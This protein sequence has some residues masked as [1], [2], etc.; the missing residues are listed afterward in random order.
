MD[1]ASRLAAC[2]VVSKNHLAYAR[3]FS[4]SFL[5]HH[6]GARLFVLLADRIDGEFTPAREPFELIELE[7]L[8]I[9][10]LPRFCFQ[11]NILELNCA[12]KPYLLRH[13]L[14]QPGITRVLYLDSDT[15]VYREL[16]EVLD[17]LERRSIVLTPHLT[18][19]AE[20]DGLKPAE[21]HIME[22]GV[23]N[24][25]FLGVRNDA[26]AA[27]FLEWWS[28]RVYDKCIADPRQGLFVDQRWLDLVPG[29]FDGVEILRHPGYNLGHWG[30]PHRR[31]ESIGG[32][33]QV[34]GAALAFFHFSGLDVDK[35][36]LISKHQDRFSLHDVPAL[37]PLFDDYVARVKAAGFAQCQTWPY[38]HARFDNGVFIPPDARRLYWSLGDGARRF[39]D[40]FQTGRGSFW[41][42]LQEEAQEGSGLSRYW[43]HVY[44]TRPDVQR[45]F[46]DVFGRD[47]LA[48]R[49]WVLN[50]GRWEHQSPEA[51]VPVGPA[52]RRAAALRPP[53]KGRARRSAGRQR[54]RQHAV[55]EGHG[56]GSE[57]H[58]AQ[59]GRRPGA[60]R[61]RGRAR[62]G[63]GQPRPVGGRRDAREPVPDQPD[64]R[65]RPRPTQVRAQPRPALLPRQVQHRLLAVGAARAAR[66]VSRQ[67]L[68]PRRG[69]GGQHLRPGSRVPRLAHPRGEGAALDSG[70]GPAHRKRRPRLL[71]AGGGSARLPLHVRRAQRRGTEEP[72]RGH[73][74]LQACVPGRA[75]RAAGAEDRPRGA[76]ACARNSKASMRASSSWTGCS[77]AKHVNALIAACDCYVSLHRSEGFGL[78]LAEA[79]ALGKPVI[80]TGYS[81]NLDFMNVSNSL[82]VRYELV[83]AGGGPS[84][85][86]ARQR[87]GRAR[88]G[89]RRGADACGLRAIRRGP[90]SWATA[91]ARSVMA[92]L[93][94][95][96]VGARIRQRLS[97]IGRDL[98]APGSIFRE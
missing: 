15:F 54:R 12:G 21:R 82:L 19:D 50:A 47:R 17:L 72:G 5:R 11:Y 51:L 32:A 16:G 79:M 41:R 90:Q 22:S 46:P 29:M 60:T 3:V 63:G 48:Y 84:T 74:R 35:P 33:V 59:P 64:A 37:K 97:M 28:A 43:H 10:D 38:A 69:L 55:R 86:S 45:M 83:R 30:L 13:V 89:S 31:V 18:A 67:L 6:P 26:N 36:E 94:P 1:R 70:G 85:L 61:R 65:E 68:L 49:S 9:P 40:P 53:A 98:D 87:V 34:N 25:G 80:A 58:A 23:Y 20:D 8:S 78:T 2:T 56:R 7:R 92:E 57:S 4:E 71:R 91:R 27:R 52:A 93:S 96:A 76:P 62:S 81:A 88:R 14:R 73:P 44:S 77:T 42:W 66:G 75:R 95:A 24:A 39:G